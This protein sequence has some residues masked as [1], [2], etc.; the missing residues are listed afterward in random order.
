MIIL[1]YD[2]VE[3][4]DSVDYEVICRAGPRRQSGLYRVTGT[5]N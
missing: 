5:I 4:G 1:W 3:G 2:A